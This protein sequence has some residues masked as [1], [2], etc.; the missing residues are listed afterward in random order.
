MLTLSTSLILIGDFDK[1][2]YISNNKD[3]LDGVFLLNLTSYNTKIIS[4]SLIVAISKE[5]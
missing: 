2:K 4:Y 1:M 3:N 5:Q